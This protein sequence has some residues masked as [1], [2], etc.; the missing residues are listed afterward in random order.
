M[1]KLVAFVLALGVSG[2]LAFAK[3]SSN[4]FNAVDTAQVVKHK[5]T[6]VS[7]EQAIDEKLVEAILVAK[8]NR[9]VESG[10]QL[11]ISDMDAQIESELLARFDSIELAY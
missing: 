5:T 2:G 10:M 8:L 1:K 4:D 11:M 3:Y 7:L 6:V 9:N